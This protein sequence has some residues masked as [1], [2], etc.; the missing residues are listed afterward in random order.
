[1]Q[2]RLTQEI[3]QTTR[4]QR[5]G[6]ILRKCV[7]CG[8]CTATCPTY[9]LLGDELDGPRGRIYLIK[10]I[11]EGGIAQRQTQFHL[12][13]CLSCRSC[14][15]TCPSG[16][17]YAQ[18]VDIGRHMMEQQDLRPLHEKIIR[19]LLGAWLPWPSR[20]RLM[21]RLTS[22]LRP[23]LPHAL[24]EKAPQIRPPQHYP[25]LPQADTA[26]Q[27]VLLLE[28]CVQSTLSP[29]TNA[30][31]EFVLQAL[32]YRVIRENP[33]SCCGAV[34]HHLNQ[35]EQAETW[36]INNLRQW[37]QLD[38]DQGIDAIV[39]TASGCG[40]MLKDYPE[41]LSHMP[42]QEESYADLLDKIKDISELFDAAALLKQQPAYQSSQQTIAFHA[43]CTLSHGHRLAEHLFDQLSKLGYQLHKPRDAHLCCG[44]AGTYSLLQPKISQRL[45]DD[46]LEALQECVPQQIITANVGCEHHLNSAGDTP[47]THW[48]ELVADDLR[49]SVA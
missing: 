47:V 33:L 29:N 16:V 3:L 24:R 48:V 13:R 11:L 32:G 38:Q 22:R 12:D 34:N 15:T 49:R 9:Q 20:N 44:S 37:Q 26:Q 4:G 17:D 21:F 1:M 28:G 46:K 25:S 36:V 30:A 10:Q 8:F 27:T 40:I 41:I 18:L 31:A 42:E 35:S 45:R 39:S 2:T 19:R 23:L 43:P 7:H 14:E 6:E 5:A